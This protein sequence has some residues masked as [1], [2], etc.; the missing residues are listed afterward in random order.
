MAFML[1]QFISGKS[2]CFKNLLQVFAK[3]IIK[4]VN[5]TM[6]AWKTEGTELYQKLPKENYENMKECV[7][8][9]EIPKYR[10]KIEL[11]L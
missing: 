7:P 5:N 6:A 3:L 4:D 9:R 1:M 8:L 10:K 11:W 2:K